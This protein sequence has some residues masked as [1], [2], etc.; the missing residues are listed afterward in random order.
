MKP[1]TW[2]ARRSACQRAHASHLQGGSRVDT[3]ESFTSL[4]GRGQG[5]LPPSLP[6]RLVNVAETSLQEGGE[7]C[8]YLPSP[9]Q[10]Q[11]SLGLGLFGPDP[12]VGSFLADLKSPRSNF[13]H[14]SDWGIGASKHPYSTICRTD[15]HRVVASKGVGPGPD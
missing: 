7:G 8:P 4:L 13:A 5:L 14:R 2:A 9:D 12:F 3:Y 11:Y 15:C 6:R 1:F 10:G